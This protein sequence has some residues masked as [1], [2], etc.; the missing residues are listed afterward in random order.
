MHYLSVCSGIEAASAAWAPL[1]WVPLGFSEVNRFCNA[2]LA[3]HYPQ[4]VNFG[5]LLQFESWSIDGPVDVLAGGTP[6]QSFSYAGERAGMDDPRGQLMFAFL[7]LAARSRARWVVWEN[8]TGVLSADGGRAFGAFLTQ[9]GELGYGFAWRCFD[10][11]YFGLAQR[12]QRVFVVGHLGAWQPAA[13]VLLE[14]EGMRGHPAPRRPAGQDTAGSLAARAGEGFN[15]QE[16]HTG[17]LIAFGGNNT[18]GPVDLATTPLSQVS[19]GWRGDFESETFIVMEGDH[20]SSQEADATAVLH[21]LRQAVGAQA[22]AVWRSRVLAAV[23]APQVLRPPLHGCG[24]RCE[25]DQDRPGLGDSTLARTE[26]V[27]AGTLRR[28]W[29]EGPDRCTPQGQCLAAQLAR[30]P[31]QALSQLPP[32]A[33]SQVRRLTPTEFERLQG[34]P[35]GYTAISYRGKPAKDGPRYRALGN[36]WAVP[37][38]RWIGRRLGVVDAALQGTIRTGMGKAVGNGAAEPAVLSQHVPYEKRSGKGENEVSLVRHM[39]PVQLTLGDIA[40][41]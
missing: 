4:V 32:E 41:S 15:G 14:P 9:L 6:C 10:A 3:H 38:A 1:G 12:R 39:H 13:A 40:D 7:A 26:D 25:A 19:S 2:V 11:Q 22:F 17:Q 30:Q 34:F 28:L 18:A 33:P 29:E 31:G 27:P 37:V 36:S 23:P 21:A 35:D 8:V 20:A 5:D 24:V 16:A